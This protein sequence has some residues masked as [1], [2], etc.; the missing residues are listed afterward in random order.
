MTAKATEILETRKGSMRLRE[1]QMLNEMS[2][3]E[4]SMVIIYPYGDRNGENIAAAASGQGVR[5]HVMDNA[6]QKE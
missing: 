4:S 6:E 1:L 2:K 3:E 5:K